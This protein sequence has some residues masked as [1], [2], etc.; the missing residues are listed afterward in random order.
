[1]KAAL[2]LWSDGLDRLLT[3]LTGI[4]KD[5]GQKVVRKTGVAEMVDRYKLE[6]GD[7]STPE[8]RRYDQ[9]VAAWLQAGGDI[10]GKPPPR[11]P[12]R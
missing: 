9:E 7:P 6:F 12:G 8:A 3:E 5:D 1:M 10:K 11:P 4:P 2:D